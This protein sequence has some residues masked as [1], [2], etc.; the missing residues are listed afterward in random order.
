MA[1]SPRF[2]ELSMMCFYVAQLEL[3]DE[4][5]GDYRNPNLSAPER[6][7]IEELLTMKMV[8]IVKLFELAQR[9][10]C[11]PMCALGVLDRIRSFLL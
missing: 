2:A 4:F 6:E 9:S 1:D 5:I 8:C 7:W 3:Y 10:T 11:V